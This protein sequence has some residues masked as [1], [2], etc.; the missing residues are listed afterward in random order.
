MKILLAVDGSAYTKRMLGFFAAH[1][2]M[3]GG[4]HDIT[5]LT[6]V[7]EL[8][9]HVRSYI[10]RS[11]VDE[12]YESQ[13]RAVLLPVIAF[14]EQQ[15]RRITALHPVGSAG[16]LIAEA[17]DSGK[18]DLVVMGSHGHGALGGLVLGS[19]TQRVLARCRVPLLIV[20]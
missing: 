11:T 12:Y 17:A 16:D 7:P 13:A 15:K 5:V 19:V 4:P 8:P 2:E 6:A 14:F 20:R 9:P 3:F 10:D 18:F 1:D